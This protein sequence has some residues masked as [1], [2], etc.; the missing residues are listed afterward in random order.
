MFATAWIGILDTKTRILK[1][2]N[3]GHNAPCFARKG[4]KFEFL[5]NKHGLFLAGM[6]DTQYKE[7]EIQLQD[8]DSLLIYTDGLTEAH[9]DSGELYGEERLLKK[10]NSADVRC[11]K[12]FLTQIKEDL[13][14]F[15]GDAEQFDDI[16]MLSISLR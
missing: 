14:A 13:Q 15:V 12:T 9:N 5:K 10:L 16:T 1:F 8:G 7:S 6:D 2:T 3:A 11:G 4:K